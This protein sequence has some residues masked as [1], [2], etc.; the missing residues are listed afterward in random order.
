MQC[1]KCQHK[2]PEAANFCMTCGTKLER[3][4]PHCGADC[5]E[6][7]VFCMK[8]GTKL[9]GETTPTPTSTEQPVE[10]SFIERQTP[11]AERRQLTVMF[12]DL[13]GSTVLSAQLDPEALRDVVRAYQEV[14]AKVI[15]RFE[16]HIAQYLGDGLLVYFGYPR[17]HEDDAQRAVRSGLGIVEGLDHLNARLKQ[18]KN[19]SLSVRVGIHTGL[20]VVGEMGGGERREQLALGETPNIAARLQALAEPNTLVI[21]IATYRLIEGFFDCQQ[22]GAHVLKGISQPIEIYQVKNESTARSRLDMMAT[23][24]LTPLVGR[25]QEVTILL[26]RWAQVKDGSGHVVLLNGEAGIGK[27]RLV[28]VLKEHV[29][30]EPGAWLTECRCSPYHQSSALYPVIDMFE[31]AAL[32]FERDESADEKL[33][34]LEGFLVQYGFSLDEATPLFASLLSVPLDERYAPLNLT[35]ER[36][37][38]KTLDAL[39]TVLLERAAQQPV[40]FVVEDLHWADPSTLELL[41]LIIDQGPT[42]RILVV[43]S[44]RPNF[45]PPWTNRSHLTQITLSH[46][47]PQQGEALV[48]KITGETALPDEVLDQVV[49]RTDGVPLFVEE[50]TRMVLESDL[51]KKRGSHYELKGPL[52]PQA[53]PTTLQ[54][55]LMARLDRLN[56]AREVAQLGATIGREFSYELLFAV[57]ILDEETLQRELGRLVEIELLYQRGIPP[58]ATYFFKHALIQDTAYQSLLLSTRQ[59]Y[60]QLIAQALA[61]RFPET[62]ETQPELLA[63]HYTEAG[64]GE[65]AIAYWQRASARAIERSANIEAVSHLT[66]GLELVRTLPQTSERDQQELDLQIALGPVLMA[67]KGYADP[68]V[69]QTYTRA[70]ELC[71]TNYGSI[72]Y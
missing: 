29:A 41:N 3:K 23:T 49:S 47:T 25:E 37:K 60:H 71:H 52:P 17:A 72:S 26:E 24:A 44:F 59:R 4:C 58:Q 63:H 18:E 55:S 46:L 21:S 66:K 32:A 51:L 19:I 50:L 57:S 34:K 33:S 15:V 61:E 20:V 54:D 30:Q 38:Q 6:K 39:L 62:A 2:N 40:L 31:R 69:E 27:S 65:E 28:Q 1:P 13:V 64:L 43:L 11:E 67:V 8:C 22:K 5:P 12:C 42:A 56:T 14:C 53:I 70:R 16:G 68:E 7:A 45:N 35:P 10:E 48:K 9:L 36:Q